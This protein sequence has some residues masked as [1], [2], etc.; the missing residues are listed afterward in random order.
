[1][2]LS[3]PSHINHI[4]KLHLAI[5]LVVI[6]SIF[7]CQPECD[8]GIEI[9]QGPVF[10]SGQRYTVE[11][12]DEVIVKEFFLF[13]RSTGEYTRKGSYCCDLDSCKVRFT[14]GGTDTVFYIRPSRVKKFVVGSNYLGRLKIITN[15][16]KDAWK[17]M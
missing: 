13:D 12:E 11:I 7:S 1:M 9:Y 10:K 16:D 17:K 8:Q 2:L 3:I 6:L 15:E 14:L 5:F 4:R